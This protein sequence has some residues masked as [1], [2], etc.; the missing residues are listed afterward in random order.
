MVT[1]AL[2]APRLVRAVLLSGVVLGLA[3]GAH[4]LGGG[5]APSAPVLLMLG[6]LVLAVTA[7]VARHRVRLPE[8]LALLGVA[9]VVLHHALTL[10][11]TTC[12]PSGAAPVGG[13]HHGA[14][15]VE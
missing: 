7:G 4:R 10:T 6:A 8:A 1:P 2:G 13:H 3:V 14:A 12:T 15:A 11:A 5:A 9:Q